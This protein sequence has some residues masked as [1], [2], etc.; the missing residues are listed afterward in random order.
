VAVRAEGWAHDAQ[1]RGH[2]EHAFAT[3]GLS[4]RRPTPG[5]PSTLPAPDAAALRWS[6]WPAG[7]A[8]R[9]ERGNRPFRPA[10]T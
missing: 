2:V 7:P 4:L 3:A 10:N 1:D 9:S 6:P 8:V 5:L